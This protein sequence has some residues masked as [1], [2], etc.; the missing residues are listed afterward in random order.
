MGVTAQLKVPKRIVMGVDP[1]TFLGYTILD[2]GGETTCTGVL[3]FPEEKSWE[4]LQL[5]ATAFRGLLVQYEPDEVFIEGLAYGN[6]FTLVLM[7]Q[8]G[9]L[10][11][12]GMK[13]LGVAWWDVPPNVL[14]KWTTGKGSADKPAMAKAVKDRWGFKSKS[15][16]VVDS[17]ALAQ[18][19][20][21]VLGMGPGS[22]KGVSRTG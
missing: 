2:E 15:D 19:G 16:D 3:N 12:L 11:R 21:F 10:V 20:R 9:T 5:I 6:K 17:F 14:K 1:S 7:T 22:L 8:I 18:L 4:R 13:D